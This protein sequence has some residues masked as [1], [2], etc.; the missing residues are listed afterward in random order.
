MAAGSDL[1]PTIVTALAAF[2]A[3]FLGSV[4]RPVADDVVARWREKRVAVDRRREAQRAHA[5][6]VVELLRDISAHQATTPKWNAA[7]AELWSATAAVNDDRLTAA[8]G[9]FL[10]GEQDA[11]SDAKWRAGERVREIDEAE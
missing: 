8:V 7:H 11:L 9:R 3:A 10:S 4:G 2:I 5:Q 6:R 1:A